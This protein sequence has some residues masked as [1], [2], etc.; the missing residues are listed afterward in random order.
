MAYEAGAD[1]LG[2][3]FV[4][5]SK[6]NVS[7][8]TARSMVAAVRAEAASKVRAG[9][10]AVIPSTAGVDVVADGDS[11]NWLARRAIL[12]RQKVAERRTSGALPLFVGVFVDCSAAE[13]NRTADEV[14]LDLIQLH[15]DE[16][17]YMPT[18]LNR[19]VIRVMHVIPNKTTADECIQRCQRAADVCYA[20]L[21]DTKLS[22]GVSGGTG[23]TFDWSIAAAVSARF[24][25]LVAGG[26]TP[27]NVHSAVAAIRPLGVDVSSGV[28]RDDGSVDKD[29]EKVRAFVRE[30][31]RQH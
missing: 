15:G 21:L 22:G 14:G 9:Q 31:K 5:T 26:L 1:M 3:I 29:V 6:R 2:L 20:V 10:T 11:G 25:V 8:E 28:E 23:V 7:V 27:Y 13:M 12:L 19:P 18:Q 24:P 17:A 30:A 16:P 4:P